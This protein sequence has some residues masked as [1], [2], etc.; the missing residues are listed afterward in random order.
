MI[1]GSVDYYNDPG[2]EMHGVWCG[3][4]P[5]G[6]AWY[7]FVGP[8]PTGGEAAVIVSVCGANADDVVKVAIYGG[9][10]CNNLVCLTPATSASGCVTSSVETVENEMYWLLI[11]GYEETPVDF[12]LS[13]SRVSVA[14]APSN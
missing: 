3:D 10:T 2:M 14:T 5:T 12:T 6:G 7:K 13:F 11:Y 4:N 8:P 1:S 9:D